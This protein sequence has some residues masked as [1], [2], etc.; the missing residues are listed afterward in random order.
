MKAYMYELK[1]SC[2]ITSTPLEAFKS[3]YK[4]IFMSSMVISR[5][6]ILILYYH[7]TK[8][9]KESPSKTQAGTNYKQDDRKI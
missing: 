4:G 6:G 2:N 7:F 9:H 5:I 3:S 8:K 1:L